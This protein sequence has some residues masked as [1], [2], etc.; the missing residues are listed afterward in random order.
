MKQGLGIESPHL[1][2]DHLEVWGL[3]PILEGS[4]P[5]MADLK[6]RP[7]SQ[8][9]TKAKVLSTVIVLLIGVVAFLV[10]RYIDSYIP[11]KIKT[12]VADQFQAQ[13]KSQIAEEVR[14]NVTSQIQITR[15]A[16]QTNLTKDTDAITKRIDGLFEILAEKPLG[17]A[18][19]HGTKRNHAGLIKTLPAT[20][21]LLAHAK[22]KAISEP[23]KA[24]LLGGSDFR[25]LA[26]NL[27]RSFNDA[28]ISRE[29]WET[30]LELASYKTVANGIE[31]GIPT[32]ATT[33]D[34][35]VSLNDRELNDEVIINSVVILGQCAT[36]LRNVTFV[37]CR[38]EIERG[39]NGEQFLRTLLTSDKQKMSL[40]LGEPPGVAKGACEK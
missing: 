20:R 29:S 40:R 4:L 23:T 11:T 17:P 37:N 28:D 36:R 25:E 2:D 1:L 30:A 33:Y 21:D 32:S 12:E 19:R 6:A 14:N 10:T 18:L 26:E 22:S 16:L 35:T 38:F 15:E 39:Q 9:F 27:L 31:Y 13:V 5:S 24:V 34:Q 7:S 3:W 8:I